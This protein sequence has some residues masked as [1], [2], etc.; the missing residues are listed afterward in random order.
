MARGGCF[1]LQKRSALHSLMAGAGGGTRTSSLC[2]GQ[3]ACFVLS[4]IACL[5]LRNLQW[6]LAPTIKKDKAL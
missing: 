2:S 5:T 4:F 1:G 3:G 6:V